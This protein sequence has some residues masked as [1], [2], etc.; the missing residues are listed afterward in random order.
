M[1][2]QNTRE[3]LIEKGGG[4]GGVGPNLKAGSYIHN[5]R[6]KLMEDTKK[7]WSKRGGVWGLL[8]SFK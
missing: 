6:E 4:G 2:V 7:D 5:I 8:F 1:F 3:R